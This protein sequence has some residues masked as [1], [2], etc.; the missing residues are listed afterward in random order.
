MLTR[1]VNRALYF[2]LQSFGCSA[3]HME[4]A[5]A[6]VSY[7]QISLCNTAI[8]SSLVVLYEGYGYQS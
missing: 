1:R 5:Q 2:F 6:F 4:V 7:I 3:K 8:I